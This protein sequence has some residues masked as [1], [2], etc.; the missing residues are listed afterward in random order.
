MES[1]PAKELLTIFLGGAE[2][3]PGLSFYGLAGDDAGGLAPTF[4]R[5]RWPMSNEP[6]SLSLHGEGWRVIEWDLHVAVWPVGDSFR[7]AVRATLQELINAGCRPGWV[8]AEG[9]PFCDPPGLLDPACM[10]G[11]VLAWL[12]SDGEFGCPLDPDR[13]LESAS[14]EEMLR[15]R[16]WAG[17]LATGSRES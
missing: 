10:T 15:L 13:P 16:A 2:E 4:P 6:E 7:A 5:D 14:D 11:G 17:P 1:A 3:V 12:T 9:F 8:G